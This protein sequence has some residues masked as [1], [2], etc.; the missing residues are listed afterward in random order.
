MK[1]LPVLF[2]IAIFVLNASLHAQKPK[3]TKAKV[4]SVDNWVKDFNSKIDSLDLIKGFSSNNDSL[5]NDKNTLLEFM[6]QFDSLPIETFNK[7]SEKYLTNIKNIQQSIML[8]IVQR[9][10]GFENLKLKEQSRKNDRIYFYTQPNVLLQASNIYII[11]YNNKKA[12][13]A[14]YKNEEEKEL[15]LQA[16]LSFPKDNKSN[17]AVRIEEE[18]T[19]DINKTRYNLFM[20]DQFAASYIIYKDTKINSIQVYELGY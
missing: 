9:V 14:Y 4:D 2:I 1:K 18:K 11:Q 12:Y 7:G 19:I 8:L 15:S 17:V 16:F 10:L 5:K 6:R 13:C 3:Q 20:G